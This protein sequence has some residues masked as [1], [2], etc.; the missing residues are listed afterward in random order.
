M[1]QLGWFK[2]SD[3]EF[4]VSRQSIRALTLELPGENKMRLKDVADCARVSPSTVSRVLN[5]PALVGTETRDR[6][7]VAIEALGYSLNFYA[8]SLAAGKSRTLGVIIS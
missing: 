4:V 8:S 1:A 2:H 3:S 5:H 6:V 7:T